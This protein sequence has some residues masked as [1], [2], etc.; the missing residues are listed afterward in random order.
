MHDAA[1]AWKAEFNYT[2]I[3]PP[4][5]ASVTGIAGEVNNSWVIL[6]Y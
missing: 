1:C 3:T 2:S 6:L 4:I 5:S